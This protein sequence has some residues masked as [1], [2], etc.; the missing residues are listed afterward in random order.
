MSAGGLFKEDT[1]NICG[2]LAKEGGKGFC[3]VG[4]LF[5]CLYP[6]FELGLG[7]LVGWMDGWVDGWDGGIW[8]VRIG[9]LDLGWVGATSS[10]NIEKPL[11]MIWL[12]NSKQ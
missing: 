2:G 6:G 10:R 11:L 9:H 12:Q 3:I 1:C 7:R 8:Q 5:L 4:V